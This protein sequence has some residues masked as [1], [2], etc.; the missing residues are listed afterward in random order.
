MNVAL[1]QADS[2]GPDRLG[3]RSSGAAGLPRRSSPSAAPRRQAAAPQ[4]AA[5]SLQVDIPTR[6]RLVYAGSTACLDELPCCLPGSPAPLCRASHLS[7]KSQTSARQYRASVGVILVWSPAQAARRQPACKGSR[8]LV[9][10]PLRRRALGPPGWGR[11]CLR[12]RHLQEALKL[13]RRRRQWKQEAQRASRCRRRSGHPK[14]PAAS[15]ASWCIC[16]RHTCVHN[17]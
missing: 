2:R 13:P 10:P 17:T 4:P 15:A 12:A 3:T 7:R 14:R 16:H 5:R 6:E 1:Q 11:A 9:P 8:Q